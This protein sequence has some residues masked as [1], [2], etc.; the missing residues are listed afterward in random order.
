MS[1]IL[2]EN[3]IGLP[4]VSKSP[5][6]LPT[7]TLLGYE[8]TNLRSTIGR[9]GDKTWSPAAE[10]F[11]QQ[12]NKFRLHAVSNLR[13][14]EM[15]LNRGVKLQKDCL[16]NIKLERWFGGERDQKQANKSGYAV[17]RTM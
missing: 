13:V 4:I 11:K 12:A 16:G 17:K 5:C 10:Y 7:H 8:S 1:L 2:Q 6:L 3:M 9:K 15:S 14:T